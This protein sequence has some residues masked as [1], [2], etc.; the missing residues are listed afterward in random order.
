MINRIAIALAVCCSSSVVL[1][2][3]LDGRQVACDP[4][5]TMVSVLTY[6]ANGSFSVFHKETC[7]DHMKDPRPVEI[8]C[9]L[10][11]HK[12]QSVNGSCEA[13]LEAGK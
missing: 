5:W 2:Q 10:D 7:V 12:W 3:S 6:D 4:G 13:G 1:A 9:S 8:E 11:G